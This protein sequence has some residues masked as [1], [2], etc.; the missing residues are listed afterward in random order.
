MIVYYLDT[1]ASYVGDI[2]GAPEDLSEYDRS[3]ISMKLKAEKHDDLYLLRLAIDYLL[4]HP[5]VDAPNYVN[6]HYDYDREETEDLLKHIKFV[7]WSTDSMMDKKLIDSV[8]LV[9]TTFEEW[10]NSKK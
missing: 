3:I 10:I 6:A 7:V 1:V 5:E 8:E 4:T 2:G 9:D